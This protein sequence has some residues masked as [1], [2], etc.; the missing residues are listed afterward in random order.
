MEEKLRKEKEEKEEE[1]AGKLT[2]EEGDDHNEVDEVHSEPDEKRS[3]QDTIAYTPGP[4]RV[5]T[6][7]SEKPVTEVVSELP[8]VPQTVFE[9]ERLDMIEINNDGTSGHLTHSL[10]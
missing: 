4:I 6:S 10:E 7:T 9:Q 2:T 1:A 5:P 8:P 3:A